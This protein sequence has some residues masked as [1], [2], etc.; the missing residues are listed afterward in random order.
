M[1]DEQ[2]K[3]GLSELINDEESKQ[4]LSLKSHNK[5][6]KSYLFIEEILKFKIKTLQVI[7]PAELGADN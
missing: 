3:D 4:L 2:G 1:I 7:N 5:N 6:P